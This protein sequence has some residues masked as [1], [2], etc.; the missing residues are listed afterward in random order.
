M[1]QR[2]RNQPIYHDTS[3]RTFNFALILA[4]TGALSP[5]Y[6]SYYTGQRL[7]SRILRMQY[8]NSLQFE[9]NLLTRLLFYPASTV[10]W[11]HELICEVLVTANAIPA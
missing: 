5:H 9:R 6:S 8:K 3:T 7:E 1:C 10:S 11:F 2:Q 4:G